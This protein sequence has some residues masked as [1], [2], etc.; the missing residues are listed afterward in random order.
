MCART[1][2]VADECWPNVGTAHRPLSQA[3]RREG[4]YD[5]RPGLGL[6]VRG[7]GKRVGFLIHN[8]CGK[9]PPSPLFV[10]SFP[11][12]GS[13]PAPET[14]DLEDARQSLFEQASQARLDPYNIHHIW[15]LGPH[16]AQ[17]VKLAGYSSSW[18]GNCY[19]RHGLLPMK[20]SVFLV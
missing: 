3:C 15:R 14:M 4:W 19:G 8:T 20:P 1:Y 7:W 16:P 5:I 13:R 17:F 12:L 6:V 11:G 9:G 2:H 10:A 18:E